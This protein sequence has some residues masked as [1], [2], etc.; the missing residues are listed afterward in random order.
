[1]T[2]RRFF[3]I[4]VII[5]IIA[6]SLSL[7]AANKIIMPA[8]VVIANQRSV[9]IVN[10]V[11]N[12][13]LLKTIYQFDLVSEDFYNLTSDEAGQLSSL[14]VDTILVSRVASLLAADISNSLSIDSPKPIA[15]PVGMLTG[16]PIFAAIGP[17]FSI[18]IIPTG[19]ARVEYETSFTSAGINQIN[20]QVWLNVT[21]TMRI[22]IPLQ[23]ETV[24]ITRRVPLVNTVF[25]GTVPEGMILTNFGINP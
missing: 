5:L 10:D 14:S 22:T 17:D 4:T 23:E 8:V 1:M 24:P 3:L 18:N 13:S 2:A 11:I 25:A 15:V 20:F 19:E 21:T 16:V 12:D 7:F 6:V 9:A